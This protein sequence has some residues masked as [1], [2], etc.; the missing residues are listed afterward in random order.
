MGTIACGHRAPVPM[1]R[2]SD[3]SMPLSGTFS[4]PVD[5]SYLSVRQEGQTSA[6]RFRICGL[7]NE[8]ASPTKRLPARDTPQFDSLPP[9]AGIKCGE[10]H[11]VNIHGPESGEKA[12]TRRTFKTDTLHFAGQEHLARG[13]R[14]RGIRKFD[15][16]DATEEHT[17]WMLR[18]F[19]RTP[20][21]STG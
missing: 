16:C 1:T 12:D 11:R 18:H 5:S 21:F 9:N 20:L 4:P 13:L 10:G 7:R 3:M 2:L 19:T 6:G 15:I 17:S 8:R 14:V